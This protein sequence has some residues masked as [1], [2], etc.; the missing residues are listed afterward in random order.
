MTAPTL[1]LG[2][3]ESDAKKWVGY[4]D[5]SFVPDTCDGHATGSFASRLAAFHDIRFEVIPD[6]GH[7]LQHDQP[8]I[9][10]AKVEAHLAG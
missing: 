6:A 1:W 9:V 5:E 2:A 10:A 4:S 8:E 7:M 3:S